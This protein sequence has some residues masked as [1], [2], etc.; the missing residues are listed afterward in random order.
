[1]PV[2]S[3]RGVHT[4]NIIDATPSYHLWLGQSGFWFDSKLAGT[5]VKQA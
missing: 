2:D 4:L 3:Q 5:C 1:M